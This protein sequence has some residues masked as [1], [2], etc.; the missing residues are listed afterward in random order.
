[1]REFWCTDSQP[2]TKRPADWHFQVSSMC[3]ADSPSRCWE[4]GAGNGTRRLETTQGIRS[5]SAPVG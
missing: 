4:A 2:G 1:M 3:T 5:L